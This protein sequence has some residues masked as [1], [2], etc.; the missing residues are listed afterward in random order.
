[1]QIAIEDLM[2]LD[3]Q[4]LLREH[5]A[6]MHENSPPGTVYALDLEGLRDPAITFWTV[7][8]AGELMGCGALK[9]LDTQSGE[10]KSMR[11]AGAHL[12]KGVAAKLLSHILDE[13]KRRGYTSVSLETGTTEA[14]QPAI[15]LYK[16][17]GFM[18]CKPL[19][20]YV[21]TDFNLFMTI[22]IQR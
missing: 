7:R 17:F 1:M 16:R 2:S 22:E 21:D 14:F 11:T 3:V 10:I 13:T 12:R 5:L 6:S 8:E 18:P 4:D 9:E 20:G 15:S 19:S